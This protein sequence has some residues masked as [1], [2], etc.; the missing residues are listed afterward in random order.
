MPTTDTVKHTLTR[1]KPR[2]DSNGEKD[3]TRKDYAYQQF[4]KQQR[5]RLKRQRN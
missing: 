5:K 1:V 3:S 2:M 4:S